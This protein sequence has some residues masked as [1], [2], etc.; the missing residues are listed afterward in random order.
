MSDD[1]KLYKDMPPDRI[2]IAC[3]TYMVRVTELDDFSSFF[4]GIINDSEKL[5]LRM[6]D[7]SKKVFRNVIGPHRVVQVEC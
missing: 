5:S 4:L 3:F 1:I 2:T 6:T 7:E